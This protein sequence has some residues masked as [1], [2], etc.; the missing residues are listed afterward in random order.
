MNK[1]KSEKALF[2]ALQEAKEKFNEELENLGLEPAYFSV[3]M[4]GYQLQEIGGK[5]YQHKVILEDTERGGEDG[6]T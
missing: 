3:D 4:T 6:G 5:A 1:V 2:Q